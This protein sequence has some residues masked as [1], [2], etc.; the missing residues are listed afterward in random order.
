MHMW[1]ISTRA[2][3]STF[4]SEKEKPDDVSRDFAAVGVGSILTD[5]IGSFAVD[6][7]PPSTALVVESGG[8]SQVASITAVA[9]MIGLFIMA[10]GLMAYVP[11]AAQTPSAYEIE[12]DSHEMG[13][14]NTDCRRGLIW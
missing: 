6:A 9:L 12:Q 7:S 11:H 8:H 5:L 14:R 13:V 10:A 4:P 3:A 1:P 2:V